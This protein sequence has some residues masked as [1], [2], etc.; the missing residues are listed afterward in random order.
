MDNTL[1]QKNDALGQMVLIKGDFAKNKV[2]SKK[3]IK[4]TAA[5]GEQLGTNKY[6]DFK[7]FISSENGSKTIWIAALVSVLIIIVFI[8]LVKRGI[9]Q[10]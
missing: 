1:T 4:Q 7:E 2:D 8:V 9:I 6:W 5:V 10:L 3:T